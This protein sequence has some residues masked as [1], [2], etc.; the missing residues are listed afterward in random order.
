MANKPGKVSGKLSPLRPLGF[1]EGL[2]AANDASA[3]TAPGWPEAVEV[4]RRLHAADAQAA[5]D[6]RARLARWGFSPVQREV[7][8]RMF[9]P[10]AAVRKQLAEALPGIAG[11]DAAPW[12]IRLAGDADAEVRLAA[13]SLL[14]TT[15]DPALVQQ[16]RRLAEA[17]PD[18]RIRD[19][20]QRAGATGSREKSPA[21]TPRPSAR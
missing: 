21:G 10:D 6:A 2:P 13:I 7:A 8:K 9:D 18:P 4:M 15:S 11:L 20:A 16:A 12:L 17:D 1:W 14:L 3:A 19:Q 5:A